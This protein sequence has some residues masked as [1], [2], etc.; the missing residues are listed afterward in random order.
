V[1]AA[2]SA[3]DGEL[4]GWEADR[5][6]WERGE[7]PGGTSCRNPS[8]AAAVVHLQR[9]GREGPGKTGLMDSQ[10]KIARLDLERVYLDRAEDKIATRSR[11]DVLPPSRF[12]RHIS[13][14]TP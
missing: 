9:A 7:F 8:L 13:Q 14:K 4:S 11:K 5:Q 2:A 10:R 1:L 12:R 6:G 3:E